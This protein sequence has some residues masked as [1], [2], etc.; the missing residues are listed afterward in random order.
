MAHFTNRRVVQHRPPVINRGTYIRKTE[1][2]RLIAEFGAQQIVSF[3]AGSDTRPFYAPV[4]KYIELDQSFVT[5][6]KVRIV[7]KAKLCDGA[8]SK[9]G[10]QFIGEHYEVHPVDLNNWQSVHD[11]LRERLDASYYALTLGCRPYF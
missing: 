8:I 4:A 1:I 9:G 3:G 6:K 5:S 10:S 2:D 11:L 7:V